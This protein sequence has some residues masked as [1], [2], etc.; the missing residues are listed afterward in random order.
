M[1]IMKTITNKSYSS[2]RIELMALACEQAAM[3]ASVI[4]SLGGADNEEFVAG[5]TYDGGW[6]LE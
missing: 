6:S 4:M 1:I 5:G 3:A 2:P